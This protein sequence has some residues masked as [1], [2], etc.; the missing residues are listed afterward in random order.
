M[1]N[2][3][4]NPHVFYWI[5]VFALLQTFLAVLGGVCIIA[6]FG[7]AAGWIYN[8]IEVRRGYDQNLVYMK[9]FRLWAI[10]TGIVG[11]ILIII[12]IFIPGRTTSI[13]MLVAKIATVDNVDW[14]IQ[15][16]KDVVD[17]IVQAI[18]GI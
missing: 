6:F 3:V 11:L 5:N 7:L 12:S 15:Q 2:Y 4:I 16:V 9:V 1:S 14:T 13:E 18:K 8:L 17:Y 10:I